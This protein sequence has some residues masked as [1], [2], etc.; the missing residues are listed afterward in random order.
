MKFLIYPAINDSELAELQSVAGD[1]QIVNAEDEETAQANIE[2]A[3]AMFGTLPPSL[4]A[5]AHKLRWLQAPM[6][7]VEHYV[8]PELANSNV[9]L[10]NLAGI[11]SD[12]IADHAITFLLMFAR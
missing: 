11:Y 5:Q 7:G 9:I 1:T 10:T 3:D 8:Y 4:L 12:Q 2:D 6:A